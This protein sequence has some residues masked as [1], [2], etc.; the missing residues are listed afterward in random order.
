MPMFLANGHYDVVMSVEP[1]ALDT[2]VHDL[3]IEQTHNFV[4]NG[5]LTH[6]LIYGF[7]GAD[8]RNILEFEESFPEAKVVRLEQ[9]YR[10]T[11]TILSVANAVISHNRGRMGKTLWTEIGEG[12]PVKIRELDDEHAEARFV[13]GEVERL[14]DEGVSRNEIAVFYRTNAQSRSSSAT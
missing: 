10:S 1:V 4:A 11:Q 12:D 7:R 2:R 9:N 6:N 14:V 8:V 3:D 5:V 13:L